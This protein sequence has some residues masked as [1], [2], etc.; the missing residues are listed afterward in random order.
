M[1][2][3]YALLG[4]GSQSNGMVGSFRDCTLLYITTDLILWPWNFTFLNTVLKLQEITFQYVWAVILSLQ[5]GSWLHPLKVITF[6]ML[7]VVDNNN[8]QWS[9]RKVQFKQ[10]VFVQA[11]AH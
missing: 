11:W 3:N 1:L 5:L 7:Y 6:N 9:H 4:I 8:G 2:K 10:T